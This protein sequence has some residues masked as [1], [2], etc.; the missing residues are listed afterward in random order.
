MN[1]GQG[2]LLGALERGGVRQSPA[3]RRFVT[4]WLGVALLLILVAAV[5]SD[6]FHH[7]DEYFQVLEFLSAKL[8]RTPFPD[9]PWEYS[10]RVRPWLQ[11][12]L[13]F[14]AARA[15][16]TMGI[17]DPFAWALSFRLFSGLLAWLSLAGLALCVHGWLPGVEA[18][19]AAVG[20]L[21]LLWFIP[22]L[23]VRT[24]SESLAASCAVLGL[25]LLVLTSPAGDGEPAQTSAVALSLVG[26]LFGLAFQ[27]RYAVG[28]M[29]ASSIAWAVVVLRVPAR[30]ALWLGGGLLLV[31]GLA[32]CVDRW[33]YGE[34]VFPPYRYFVEN[35]I[36]S[37]AARQFGT[38][39]WYGYLVI[40]LLNALAPLVL[41][42]M[43][44][45]LLAWVRHPLHPL[46]WASVPFFLAHSLLEHK[47][48]RFLFPIA[49][50]T[51]VFLVLAAAPSGDRWDRWL[52]PLWAARSHP[53]VRGLVGLNLVALALFCLTPTRPQVSFQRFIYRHFPSRFEAYLLTPFSPYVAEGLGM[54]FY[55]PARLDLHQVAAL[56]DVEDRGLP[57]FFLV[58][59]SWDRFEERGPRYTCTLLYRPFPAWFRDLA[60]AWAARIPAWD[61]YRCA[62]EPRSPPGTSGAGER[63]SPGG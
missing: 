9:L 51:P 60:K 28:V 13:Y 29:I 41:V 58:T 1:D 31:T 59:G 43:T 12:A 62:P 26:L 3:W 7:P 56:K 8:G 11:P 4:G 33:G 49:V 46:T 35:L 42:L 21:C 57:H 40:P 24:S 5:Q 48:V 61:L 52:C 23:A 44:A 53:A 47:E 30:R 50:M 27:F 17:Q 15:W 32:A 55:R 45:T 54:Y 36:E 34:W 25:S 6:G 18:R 14:V 2:W 10:H 19:R 22:Y 16:A 63:P 39:P 37:R 38:Y 20:A